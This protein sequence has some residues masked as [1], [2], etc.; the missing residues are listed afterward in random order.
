M[1]RRADLPQK[2]TKE[3]TAFII[4]RQKTL[5]HFGTPEKFYLDSG[6]FRF[7]FGEDNPDGTPK[8]IY[9]FTKDEHDQYKPIK[10]FPRKDYLWFT[11]LCMLNS[12]LFAVDKSRQI[13]MSWSMAI[14]CSWFARTAP[15]RKILWMAQ[16]EENA[17]DMVSHGAKN[18]VEGRMSFIEIHLPGWV[19]DP[20]VYKGDGNQSGKLNF[21]QRPKSE[22]G[23][24]VPGYGSQVR[25]VAHGADKPRS[26]VPTL[27]AIDE[28]AFVEDMGAAWAT[29]R[30]AA[31]RMLAISTP[32]QGDFKAIVKDG[33]DEGRCT[34]P[35]WFT[36]Y[37]ACGGTIPPYCELYRTVH[38]VDVLKINYRTD[39]IKRPGT[40]EGDAWVEK[41]LEGGAYLNGVQSANW[42]REYENDWDVVGGDPV[43]PFAVDE[44]WAAYVFDVPEEVR[45]QG[46]TYYAGYDYGS[47]NP[48][49]FVVWAFARDGR[50]YAVW[51]HYAPCVGYQDHVN[52][53][54]ESCPYWDDL[55]WI[56]AD[57]SLFNDDQQTKHGVTSKAELLRS[58]GMPLV[59]GH[60][61]VA[62]A[63]AM[64]FL[65]HY[66]ADRKEPLAYITRACRAGKKEVQG[67]RWKEYRT[68]ATAE[69]RNAPEEIMDKNNHWWDAS[70]YLFDMRPRLPRGRKKVI[71]FNSFS[72]VVKWAEDCNEERRGGY[73]RAI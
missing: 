47:Q 51:E 73:V 70:S 16:T 20:S 43:F 53:I 57:P 19:R 59:K 64:K 21:M 71:P 45:R 33:Y 14:F 3:Q 65:G 37:K 49:A 66:W 10:P 29:A 41:Q 2:R 15:F 61:G 40:Y 39:P 62:E 58:A 23:I 9:A 55:E 52:E 72:E 32:G 31:E 22:D 67:L 7:A 38:G 4:E 54:R 30:P 42:L 6:L 17:C 18:P 1:P 35:R 46:L 44:S 12:P 25:A 63:I 27:F 34:A 60:R 8:N 48:S 5:F 26:F 56:V 24:P 69:T 68:A 28:A 50:A 13:M 36:E 11:M